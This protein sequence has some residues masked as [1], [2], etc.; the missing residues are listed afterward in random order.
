[1]V[2]DKAFNTYGNNKTLNLNR[3]RSQITNKKLCKQFKRKI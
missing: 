1:M 3:T 2:N